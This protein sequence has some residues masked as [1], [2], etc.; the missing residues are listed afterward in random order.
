MTVFQK[1]L[2][3]FRRNSFGEKKVE[4]VHFK[5][6]GDGWGHEVEDV[7][8]LDFDPL[9]EVFFFLLL[10]FSF[11]FFSFLFFFL[12]KFINLPFFLERTS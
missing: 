8:T 1:C 4:I 7:V 6:G 5:E 11:L 12:L 10:S 2:V 9:S 3:L